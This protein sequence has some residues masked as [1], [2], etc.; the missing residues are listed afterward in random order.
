M[1]RL[2]TAIVG[3]AFA[4]SAFSS[5]AAAGGPPSLSFYIDDVRYRTVGTPTD[6][7]GT[8]APAST[9]DA[10]YALGPGLIN[11]AE[12]KPGDTDFNG[13]RWAVMPITWN[14]TPVQFTNAEQVT[15]AATAG[16]I[17]IGAPI[18]YFFFSV[19]K[20]PPSWNN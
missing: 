16:D 2:I 6:F 7:S 5:I 1:R 17:S 10:I 9:Y 12:A 8:G 4:L 11:V 14:V 15:A 18:R 3:G 19:N 20:V 13:G